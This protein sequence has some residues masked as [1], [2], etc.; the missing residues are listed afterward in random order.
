[1]EM[2]LQQRFVY[3]IG[4]VKA[5]LQGCASA[6]GTSTV[7]LDCIAKVHPWGQVMMNTY[8][9]KWNVRGGPTRGTFCG[10]HLGRS[11]MYRTR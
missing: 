9:R 2:E 4:S 11:H 5:S 10:F 6:P 7:H 1:M 3:C 8:A